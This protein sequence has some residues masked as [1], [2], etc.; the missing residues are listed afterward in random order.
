MFRNMRRVDRDKGSLAGI[1]IL[2]NSDVSF[3]S[4]VSVD[5][6]YPYS[7]PMNHVYLDG[8]IYYHCSK[9]GHKIDNINNNSKVCISAV[10]EYEF[11]PDK[12]TV[13][14]KSAVIFGQASIVRDEDE[15][16]KV[17]REVI[18]IYSTDYIESGNEYIEKLFKITDIIKVTPEKIS[19]K[20]SKEL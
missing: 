3:L 14:Y 2:K 17:L 7:V 18:K 10:S 6:G 16:R 13:G 8:N 12:F 15:K 11:M 1:E 20:A 4:T 9:K 5:D 19:G